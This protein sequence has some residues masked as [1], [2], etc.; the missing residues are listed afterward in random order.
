ML[1]MDR[2]GQISPAGKGAS[3]APADD[4][5]RGKKGKFRC[6][7]CNE[8]FQTQ[9]ILYN[10]QMQKHGFSADLIRLEQEKKSRRQ[11]LDRDVLSRGLK[12]H[13]LTAAPFVML[14]IFVAVYFV[15]VAPTNVG[16]VYTQATYGSIFSKA[17]SLLSSGFSALSTFIAE[18]QNPNL[19]YT[20]PQIT[21]INSTPTFLSFLTF[22]YTPNQQAVF[23]ANPQQSDIFYAVYN[24][25][26]VPLGPG[27][28]NDL[29]VNISCGSTVSP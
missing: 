1:K 16:I 19:L 14:L 28:S 15:F 7:V 12:K 26:N 20:Q 24:N 29:E 11:L 3:D 4:P 23:T 9:T 17:S 5:F 2:K 8:R 10:H 25:G 18:V 6:S 21:T 27:T 13:S 22:S